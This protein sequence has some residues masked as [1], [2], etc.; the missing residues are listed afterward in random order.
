MI[1]YLKIA[2]YVVAA[3]IGA[4]GLYVALY[5]PRVAQLEKQQAEEREAA[6]KAQSDFLKAAELK[7]QEYINASIALQEKYARDQ[8]ITA[9]RI[10]DLS[11]S[12]DG[13]QHAIDAY[14]HPT[15]LPQAS[16]TTCDARTAT[17]GKLLEEA[18]GLAES[19]ASD[20]ERLADEVRALQAK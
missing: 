19:F 1:P 15:G 17:L 12:R 18:D 16:A 4:S 2:S 3:A 13:L 11:A 14:S 5:V 8:A 6:A 10:A 9:K 20:A 7:E